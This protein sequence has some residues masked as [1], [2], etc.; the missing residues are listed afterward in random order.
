MTTKN[1][2]HAIE[3]ANEQFIVCGAK[4]MRCGFTTGSAAAMASKAAAHFLLTGERLKTVQIMTPK[5]LFARAD[6]IYPPITQS[7]PNRFRC[8]IVKDAGDD[9]DATD[10][11]TIFATVEL[12]AGENGVAVAIDGAK[13]V[14][15][16]T[17]S[18]L[19]QAVG[20]AAINSVPRK[21]IENEI[22]SE[23]KTYGFSGKAIV[24]I[25]IPN[26]EEIAKKTFNA[27][28]GIIGGLSVIGTTGIVEPMSEKALV[29]AL[30]AEIKVIAAESPSPRS[31]I[32]T[33]GEY[34]LSFLSAFAPQLTQIPVVKCSN[35]IGS[36]LDL[37]A[38]QGF[39][40][41]L[42]SG[43]A[44]KFVKLAGGIFSTHS[45]TA[46]CRL[47]LLAAHAALSGAHRETVAAIMDCATVDAALSVL[48]CACE[49]QTETVLQSL[50]TKIEDHLDRRISG[51]FKWT[52]LMFTNVRG[53]LCHSK[54]LFDFINEMPF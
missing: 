24:T 21:M 4:K 54:N 37:I 13:G 25:D 7:E 19:D 5:R 20:N 44:G 16:V 41:V 18:G 46:D 52:F 10:G 2:P 1:P 34:G 50:L 49:V 36:A 51:A 14:G 47:E 15:R 9:P 30:E 33:P 28:L 32:V 23:C 39:S 6:V 45:R 48:D 8:G 31:I 29:D 42:I 11:C 26:G 43:H 22:R 40:H 27:Q 12:I 17:K 38:A 35:F 3:Y 53:I